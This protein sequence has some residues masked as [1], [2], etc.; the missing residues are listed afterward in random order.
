M[1]RGLP[2]ADASHPAATT[3]SPATRSQRAAVP[4][5]VAPPAAFRNKTAVADR[6][7]P[8]KTGSRRRTATAPPPPKDPRG[9]RSSFRRFVLRFLASLLLFSAASTA[10]SIQNHLSPLEHGLARAAAWGASLAHVQVDR[11]GNSLSVGG[12]QL[13]INHEC[14]AFFV[15]LI[16]AS[17]LLAYPATVWER[18]RGL[19]QGVAILMTVNV[20]RLAGLVIVVDFWP[21]LFDYFHEYFWQVL[22]LGLTT[23]LAHRWLSTLSV[24]RELLVLP[25]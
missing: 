19:L 23:V 7:D 24:H 20:I 22:F 8:S 11:R 6:S 13:E 10:L 18:T 4:V 21:Q 15:V 3:T 1:G 5:A 17:F 2:P 12:Y 9:D 16:Y 14:T 25:R